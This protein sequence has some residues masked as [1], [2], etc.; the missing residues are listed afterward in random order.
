MKTFTVHAPAG[1]DSA[2]RQPERVRF[3]ADRFNWA[4]AAFG[5]LWLMRHRLWLALAGWIA[6]AIAIGFAGARSGLLAPSILLLQIML[7]VLTG[8]EAAS[9]QRYGLSRRRFAMINVVTA[10]N[11]AEAER[12]FF[13][14]LNLKPVAATPV[15]AA[16]RPLDHASAAGFSPVETTS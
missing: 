9:L 14:R 3:I 1:V 2:M 15:R 12:I 6:I 13:S 8:L 10:Q 11:L 16:V 7:S 5:P 4:A